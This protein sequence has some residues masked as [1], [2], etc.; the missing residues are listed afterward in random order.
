MQRSANPIQ[1]EDKI[2]EG[3][4]SDP[5]FSFLNPA[6][7]YHGY[8]RHKMARIAQGEEDEAPVVPEK[9]EEL[10]E[11]VSELPKGG[12]MPLEPPPADFILD[13]PQVG[14]VDL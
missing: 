2:R 9:M 4:R 11:A 14:P 10:V 8:Y 12:I 1:F 3:Q 6:D 13:V 5:K 7:P